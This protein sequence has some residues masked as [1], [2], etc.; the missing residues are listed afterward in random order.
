[1]ELT[2]KAKYLVAKADS[3]KAFAGQGITKNDETIV[4]EL[5]V[6]AYE[7]DPIAKA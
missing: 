2:T 4:T 5:E 1:M 7:S 3:T 6:K